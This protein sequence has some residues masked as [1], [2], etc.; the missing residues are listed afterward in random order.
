MKIKAVHSR[1][2]IFLMEIIIAILFFALVSAVCLQIFVKAHGMSSRTAELNLAVSLTSSMAE[3]AQDAD[4]PEDVFDAAAGFFAG[5]SGGGAAVSVE[6]PAPAA[7]S[8]VVCF[9]S[10]RKV[11]RPD[12]ED[13]CCRLYA[14]YDDSTDPV[15]WTFTVMTAPAGDTAPEETIYQLDVE[16]HYGR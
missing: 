5:E 16:V 9:D 3:L 1:S 8:M 4:R 11:C 6:T 7:D 13:C 14:F 2:G 10:D 15:L 12:A